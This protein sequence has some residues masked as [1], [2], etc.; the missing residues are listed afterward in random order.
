M[1]AMARHEGQLTNMG[2]GCT[3]N[4]G[5]RGQGTQH[6]AVRGPHLVSVRDT[7]LETAIELLP[8]AFRGQRDGTAGVDGVASGGVTTSNAERTSRIFK[9][10]QIWTGIGSK[11]SLMSS[12][13]WFQGNAD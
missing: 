5:G 12:T 7:A 10:V 2:I 4:G 13:V 3:L 1:N 6:G 8:P 9:D 11:S